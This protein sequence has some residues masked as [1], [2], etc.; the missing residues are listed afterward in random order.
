MKIIFA[1]IHRII[2]M[3]FLFVSAL[4]NAQ[5]EAIDE[6][7]RT[8]PRSFCEPSQLADR[9][10]RDFSLDTEKTRAIF[11]WIA[12]NV[13]Y[14]MKEYF[15][16]SGI[17]YSYKSEADRIQKE[18]VFRKNLAKR[19]ISTAKGIC[20]GYST[21]FTTVCVLTG[22]EA[23]IIPGTSRNHQSQIGKLPTESDHAW[24]AVK[25]DGKWK[26]IDLSWA[27][28]AVDNNRKF[29]KRFN[30]VY[31]CTDPDKFALNHFPDDPRWLLTKKSP[32]EFAE[33]PFFFTEYLRSDYSFNIENGHIRFSQNKPVVFNIENLRPSDRVYYITSKDNV[34]DPV[35]VD[36]NNNF[37]IYPSA[38]MSGYLTIFI[39]E[40]P[41]V[42][43]RILRS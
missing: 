15:S 29:Q 20:E 7:V 13:T 3:F 32:K 23:V 1:P 8:Y 2:L 21:L 25:I 6:R 10:N 22:L 11:T 34:L 38:K 28:G 19:T 33:A 27:A 43:Y 18:K 24:N 12:T 17:A 9:I 4:S 35:R 31:F 40:K 16:N 30:D 26:L 39:N 42:S 37:A 14:D 5:Y 41:V 36:E